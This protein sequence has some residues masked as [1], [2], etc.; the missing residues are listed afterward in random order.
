M[1]IANTRLSTTYFGDKAIV[2]GK[3]VISGTTATGDVDLATMH[4][5]EVDI[6]LGTVKSATASGVNCNEDFP[7][8]NDITVVTHNNDETFY[9]VAIGT[10][11]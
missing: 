11:K 2:F 9:W 10:P 8:K 5:K 7:C 1:A 6:F 4:L 3:S